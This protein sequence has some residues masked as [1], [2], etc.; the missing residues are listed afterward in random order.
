MRIASIYVRRAFRPKYLAPAIY[1]YLVGL[2]KRRGYGA[3]F[4]LV[5]P[6]NEPLLKLYRSAGASFTDYVRSELKLKNIPDS[7]L[8]P[9]AAE[10]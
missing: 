10:L 2:A 7:V 3:I 4:G 5:P 8:D 6:T 9:S 1:F